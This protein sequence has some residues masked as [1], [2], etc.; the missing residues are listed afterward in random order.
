MFSIN[1]EKCVGC[2]ACAFTC[3]F[4]CIQPKDD[5]KSKYF[6]HSDHCMECAQCMDICPNSAV[7]PPE[8]WRRLKRVTINAEKCNGCATCHF[9]CLARAPQG[10][11]GKKYEIVQEKCYHCGVCLQHCKQDAIHAEYYDE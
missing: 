8:G 2:G 3:M 7:E 1:E 10:E 6:I 11:R 9:V 4:K 5:A